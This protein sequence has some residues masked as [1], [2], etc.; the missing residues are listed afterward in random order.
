TGALEWQDTLA[1]FP[2][3]AALVAGGAWPGGGTVGVSYRSGAGDQH[4][5]AL[6]RAEVVLS[7]AGGDQSGRY[8]AATFGG[9]VAAS[10]KYTGVVGATGVTTCGNTP[11]HVRWRRPTGPVAQA[12]RTD[13]NRLYV[14]ESP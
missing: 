3:G 10:Q 14:A 7:D 4:V 9:A 8:P 11:G 1:G 6:R 5:G 2:A 13:G 12:W